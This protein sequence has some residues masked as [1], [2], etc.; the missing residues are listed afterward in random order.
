LGIHDTGVHRV[1]TAGGRDGRITVLVVDDS[2]DCREMFAEVLR[3]SGLRVLEARDGEEA[4][5]AATTRVPDVIFMDLTLQRLDGLATTRLLKQ[6]LRT[7]HIPVI[8]VTGQERAE[9]W[10]GAQAAGCSGFIEKPC[11]PSVLVQAARDAVYGALTPW[12]LASSAE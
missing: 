5:A 3:L 12:P 9:H 11:L 10:G 6:N 2:D 7:R 4:I 1:G 8:A